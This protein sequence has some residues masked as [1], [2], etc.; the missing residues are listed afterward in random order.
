MGQ[1][2]KRAQARCLAEVCE[3]DGGAGG[4]W[5]G[6]VRAPGRQRSRSDLNTAVA[7][8]KARLS[9]QLVAVVKASGLT[10]SE[11]ARGA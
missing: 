6:V 3:D 10:S 8:L 5:E 1:G 11:E 7:E 2:V 9:S 4:R